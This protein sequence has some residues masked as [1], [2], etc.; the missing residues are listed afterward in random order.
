MVLVVDDEPMMGR[1]VT[2]MLGDAHDV[3]A[4]TSAAQALARLEEESAITPSCATHDADSTGWISP[5]NWRRR[6]LRW[7]RGSSS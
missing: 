3:S 5:A 4:V 6:H 7:P 1:A 2:R